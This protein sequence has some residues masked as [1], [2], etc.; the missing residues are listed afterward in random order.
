LWNTINLKLSSLA[1]SIAFQYILNH[2]LLLYS[3]K[4]LFQ[5]VFI[6]IVWKTNY[7]K[8]SNWNISKNTVRFG[9]NLHHTFRIS[10]LTR[11]K[12]FNHFFRI[13]AVFWKLD[14]LI[15]LTLTMFVGYQKLKTAFPGLLNSFSIHSEA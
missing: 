3:T 13:I 7:F 5:I 1:R 2:W 8:I 11:Q 9:L 15:G 4:W 12:W 10:C 6:D 14:R